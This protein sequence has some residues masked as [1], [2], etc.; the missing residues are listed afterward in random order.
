MNKI[1][2][3]KIDHTKLMPGIYVSRVDKCFPDYA[4]TTFD[5]RFKRPNYDMLQPKAAHTI[6]HL[7]A[8]YLRNRQNWKDQ[9]IYFGPMGCM[10]GFYLIVKGQMESKDIVEL[11]R[12]MLIFIVTFEGIVPGT[13][14][15][16]CG[17]YE[18]HDLAAAKKEAGEFLKSFEYFTEQNLVYPE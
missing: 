16:E 17:N 6:E 5:I 18:Y 12:D 15:E 10:T 9:I 11:V 14:P 13:T 7:G 4:V 8:T 2:S 1:A 3:F